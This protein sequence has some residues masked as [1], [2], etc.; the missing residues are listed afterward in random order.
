MQA[1]QSNSN[2]SF[3]RIFVQIWKIPRLF[4]LTKQIVENPKKIFSIKSKFLRFLAKRNTSKK[5]GNIFGKE[6]SFLRDFLSWKINLE[7]D[8]LSFKNVFNW[9]IWI[10][11]GKSYWN[12]WSAEIGCHFLSL[13]NFMCFGFI[14]ESR[15]LMVRHC[16]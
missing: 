15:F 7:E 12:W 13:L 2:N 4:Q 10:N 11:W 1:L 3:F 8:W 14:I 16:Y 6:D 5:T 9:K